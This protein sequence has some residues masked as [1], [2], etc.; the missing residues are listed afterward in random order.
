MARKHNSKKE[1]REDRY[2][3]NRIKSLVAQDVVTMADIGEYA[4]NAFSEDDI[5][6]LH[7][8]LVEDEI[9]PSEEELPYESRKPEAIVSAEDCTG[10]VN[11]AFD[12]VAPK[13]FKIE[14]NDISGAGESL[15]IWPK[16]PNG[17]SIDVSWRILP[18]EGVLAQYADDF[19]GGSTVEREL[20]FN[21][22]AKLKEILIDEF[23]SLEETLGYAP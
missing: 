18:D 6:K 4:L 5:E 8:W 9:I 1:Y 12:E 13:L 7:N 22:L 19:H 16:T 23:E 14:L 2:Y 10:T 20:R 3:T 17:A 11:A 21:D 15:D